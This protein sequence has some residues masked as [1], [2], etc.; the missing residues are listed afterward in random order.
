[1][2]YIDGHHV[3]GAYTLKEADG[4][5][6]IV[7]CKSG[8]HTGFE[9]VV[10]RLGHAQH[11]AHYGHGHGGHG[12]DSGHGGN[13]GHGGSGGSSYVGKTHWGNQGHGH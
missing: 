9:A 4:T 3:V 12:E 13:G 7:K 10:E 11:P 8:P 5:F 1:M 6:R 2:I